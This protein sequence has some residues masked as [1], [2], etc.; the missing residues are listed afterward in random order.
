LLERVDEMIIGGG[1]AFTFK[2]VVDGVKIGDSIF[3]QEGAKIVQELVEKAKAKGVKLHLPVDY[4]TADKF[5]ADAKLE[6][7]TDATGIPDGW[8]G[9]DIGKQSIA[10]FV[11]AI[12]R[13]KTI[14]WNGYE[15]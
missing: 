14:M 8:R 15:Y 5:A 3:D 1:M 13:A 12:K 11:D 4:A 10:N 7:A 9:L 6:Y 2:K